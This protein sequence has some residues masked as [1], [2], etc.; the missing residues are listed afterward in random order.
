[1]SQGIREF[2]V[3]LCLLVISKATSIKS[4]QQGCPNVSRTRTTPM[5]VLIS[6]SKSPRGL[7]PTQ[8]ATGNGEKPRARKAVLTREDHTNWLSSTKW[9]ALKIYIQVI[10]YGLNRFY[11]GAYIYAHICIQ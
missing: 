5:G 1:M 2:A 11:L 7:D 6:M 4:Y 9:S 3:R 10:V 8:L